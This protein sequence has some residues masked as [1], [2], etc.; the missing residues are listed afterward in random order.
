MRITCGE[1]LA[2]F[3]AQEL[4]CSVRLHPD[5]D[6]IV[7]TE[8]TLNGV[9]P[10]VQ[11]SSAFMSP[12]EICPWVRFSFGTYDDLQ[13]HQQ[14]GE[15]S[16]RQIRPTVRWGVFDAYGS[17]GNGQAGSFKCRTSQRCASG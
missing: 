8:L 16:K 4:G 17:T 2:A 1:E 5:I 9:P 12:F 13:W 3:V 15:I 14:T 10:R 7:E 11:M 6:S